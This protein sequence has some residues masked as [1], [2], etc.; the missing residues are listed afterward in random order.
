MSYDFA[1]WKRSET[2]K[3]AMLAEAYEALSLGRDHPAMTTFD[4]EQLDQALKNEFGNDKDTNSLI[5]CA[6]GNTANADW[7]LVQCSFADAD[8]VISKIVPIV[9]DLELLVYDP[10]KEIVWG[11]KRPR[12]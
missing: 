10:Q 8:E 9:L 3:T 6:W 7:L 12:K 1:I 4:A 11:N 5:A 2:T